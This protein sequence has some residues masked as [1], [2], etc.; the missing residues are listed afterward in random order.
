M[1]LSQSLFGQSGV[2]PWCLKHCV[3]AND[4]CPYNLNRFFQFINL[5][6]PDTGIF[7]KLFK[8]LICLIRLNKKYDCIYVLANSIGAYFSMHT[9]QKAD[10][11]KAFFISPILDMERLILDMMRWAEVSEDEL[12]E[13]EEIPTDFGETLSWKY[14]CYVR[15]NPISWEIPTEILYGENDSMTTL[16][17]VKKFMD[18]HKAHLTVMKGGEH[19]FHTKEQLAF[20]NDWMRSVI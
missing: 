3:I 15:A 20:L 2:T 8:G 7:L 1:L 5:D 16:Q 14:L 6:S 17:T 9:L 4:P 11:K 12:A 13:K 10:I 19:W 18:S